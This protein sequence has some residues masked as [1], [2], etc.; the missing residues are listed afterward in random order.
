MSRILFVIP[1]LSGSMRLLVDY[2]RLLNPEKYQLTLLSLGGNTR[3]GSELPSRTRLIVEKKPDGPTGWFRVFPR[4]LAEARSHDLIV[5]WAELTHT[6]L[7][8]AA[9]TLV[10]KPAVGWMH[11]NLSEVLRCGARPSWAHRPIMRILYPRL[12]AVVAVSEDVALDLRHSFGMTNVSVITNGIDLD[13]AR[14]RSLEPIPASTAHLFEKPA[15]VDVALLEY[16][17]NHALLLRAHAEVIRQKVEHNLLLVGDG[18]LRHDL[19]KLAVALGV[20]NSVHFLGYIDNPLPVVRASTACVLTSR[21][22]GFGIVLVE[23]MA[24]GTPVIAVDCRSGPRE[25]LA[26]GEFGLLVP[27]DDPHALAE[28]M[29]R[30]LTDA[31]VCHH[32]RTVGPQGADRFCFTHR[33]KQVEVLFDTLLKRSAKTLQPVLDPSDPS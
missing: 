33:V 19:E 31:A 22:E 3:L 28:A 27:P 7:A 25:I 5:G 20:S 13:M 2:V 24:I 1:H 16:Q 32:F 4:I 29:K 30:V 18:S 8:V 26:D 15:L 12:R 9:A 11:V 17:K 23:A 10:A 21:W 6:Y 14:Q